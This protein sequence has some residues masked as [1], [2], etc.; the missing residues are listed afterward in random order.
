M[1]MKL[2]I[3]EID[4]EVIL[5]LANKHKLSEISVFGS[6]LRDNFSDASD[7]D[8]LVS[9]LPG[10]PASLFDLFALAEDF[11]EAFKRPVDVVER[12]SLVNPYRKEEILRTARTVYAA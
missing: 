6:V 12:A 5:T 11:E 8:I 3:L 4:D 9:F 10:T 7:V 1:I 2:G